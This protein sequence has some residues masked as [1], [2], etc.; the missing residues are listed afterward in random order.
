VEKLFIRISFE[1]PMLTRLN[2][3]LFFL[4][5]V[6]YSCQEKEKKS[7]I[8]GSLLNLTKRFPQLPKSKGE[9]TKF[10]GLVRSVIMGTNGVE[11]QLR[12]TPDSVDD[13]QK[14]ILVINKENRVYG[15]PLFSNTYRD[16]WNFLFDSILT[17]IKP[18]NT[19]FQKELQ[20]CIDTLGLN[21]TLG[22]GARLIN[23]MLISLL[24]CSVIH[25][26][27]SSDIMVS[28]S[29]S[30]SKLPEEDLDS[31]R[32]KLRRAWTE[33]YRAMHPQ[34]YLMV[35]NCFWDEKD[36]RIYQF[37]YSAKRKEKLKVGVRVYRQDCIQHLLYL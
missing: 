28:Y 17:S 5:F 26:R 36:G 15:V 16:Y 6:F 35:H 20:E 34:T 18:V 8:E 25:D 13:P 14:V 12:S 7:D 3:F 4:F 11:L 1:K 10:Y 9:I 22:T 21:D 19:T 31:C 37:D 29:N 24:R 27:D 33:I 30:N 32:T 2:L 23:E